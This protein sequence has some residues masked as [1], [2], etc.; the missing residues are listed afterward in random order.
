MGESVLVP[1]DGSPLSY[2]A[3]EYAIETF[4]DAEIVVYHVANIY[5]PGYELDDASLQELLANA[6]EWE[7]IERA[8]ADHLFAEAQDIA[9]ASGRQIVTDTAVGDP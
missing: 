7:A 3:L 9:A 4:P 8:A 6:P 5:E 1:I 2:R